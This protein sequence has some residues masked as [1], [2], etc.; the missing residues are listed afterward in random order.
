MHVIFG[1]SAIVMAIATVM[2]MARDHNREWK[3]WTL[4]DRKKDAWMIQSRRDAAAQQYAKLMNA[5]E[6]ELRDYDSQAV[7]TD[8]VL[9]FEELVRQENERLKSASPTVQ[10][11]APAAGGEDDSQEAESPDG[12][13]TKVAYE[14]TLV[15]AEGEVALAEDPEFAKLNAAVADLDSKTPAVVEAKEKL[16]TL[17]AELE[18]IVQAKQAGAAETPTPENAEAAAKSAAELDEQ[19]QTLKAEIKAAQ[20]ALWSAQDAAVVAR[21]NVLGEFNKFIRAAKFRETTLVSRKKSLNGQRTAKVSELGI[22]IGQGG[23]PGSVEKLQGEVNDLDRQVAELT[24]AIA[25][26][27]EYRMALEQV[28]SAANAEKVVAS[29]ELDTMNTELKRLDEQVAQNTS[30]AGEW[31]TRLPILNALYSGNVKVEQNWLPDLTINYNFSQVAR[32]DRCVT[33]HRGI[34][35]TAPGTASDP[36]YP[37]LPEEL[38][39]VTVQLA[40][41]EAQPAA[42][43]TLVDVYG[44]ELSDSGIVDDAA[45]TVHYVLPETPAAK[46]GI[47][48]GDVIQEIA[49]SR[50]FSPAEASER[51]LTLV[52]W[53]AKIPVALRRG[54]D[55]PY[56]SHPRLDLY[57][58]DTSPHPMKDVG[59]TICHDGQG[60]GTSFSWTSHTPN[61]AK[62]QNR[63][64]Q[65]YGWFDNHHW[66]FPMKPARFVESNCLKCHH[67]KGELEPS[68]KFP[69]PPAPQVVEGWTLVEEYGCFGCHEINGWDSPTASVG[70]DVRLEPNYA[71]VA[72]AILHSKALSDG[73]REMAQQLRVQPSNNELR[74]QLLGA[75]ASKPTPPGE[76]PTEAADQSPEEAQAQAELSRLATLLKDVEIPGEYRKV[77]PSLRYIKS[78]VDYDWLYSWVRKPA[79]FRPSTKMPQFFGLHEHLS[80]P[81]DASQ[82]AESQRFEPIEIRAITEYLLNASDDFEYLEPAQG[83]TEQASAERGEWQFESRGCLACHAHEEFPGIA[84]NQGPDLS[85]LGAKLNTEKGRRWLYSWVKQPNRY[86]ARTVMPELYIGPIVEKNA[87]NQPTGVVTDPAA[88]ITAFLLGVPTDWQPTDVPASDDWTVEDKSALADLAQLWLTSDAIPKGRARQYLEGEGFAE[89][90]RAKLKTNERVLI[91]LTDENRVERQ[92]EFVARNTI[93]KY[94]CFGCHD[95]PGFEDA[96]PIG[97]ALADWGRKETSKLAFENIH[98]FLETHSIN[99]ENPTHDAL[100]HADGSANAAET[101]AGDHAAAEGDGHDAAHAASH[102]HLDPADF[103]ADESYFVQSLNSHGRDGFIWQKLR[104]PRSYDYKTTRNKNFN[105]RLRM[106]KFPFN[107]QQRQAVI[108]F[109]LGL[110]KEPPATKFLFNPDA[111]QQAIVDGRQVLERFNCG[112]CHTLKMEQW[113]FGYGSDTFEDASEV[114]DYPFLDPGFTDQ[115]IAASLAKDTRGLLQANIAGQPVFDEETGQPTWVDED[116]QPITAEEVMEAE[117]EDG[118]AISVFYRFGLW[119]NELINGQPRLRGVDELLIPA[120][121]AKYGPANGN[122]Y[123]AWGGDLARYLFPKVIARAKEVNPQVNGREAWGWLPPPLMDEGKKVQTDWLHGFLMDPTMIRPAVVMRMPNFHMSSEEAEK[124]VNYFAAMSEAQFPFEYKPQQ[125]ANY[126]TN[127]NAKGGDPLAEAMNIVTNGNYCVKCHA[128]AD[129]APQGD[130]NTFGPN[131]ADV[132]SRL[133]PNFT[134]D[135]IAN[136]ARILPYTG[137]P[138]NIPYRPDDP[139]LGGVAQELYHGTSVQQLNGLVDLLM[140]FDAYARRNTSVSSLVERAAAAQPAG[141]ATPPAGGASAADEAGESTP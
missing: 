138:V 39:N 22:K 140:N 114:V 107:D 93:G 75:L 21:G 117:Q 128:V 41:P 34:A 19:E 97:T 12:E 4:K 53:N 86:H 79:D 6:D 102:G 44:M 100:P 120:D 113:V 30:N 141:G 28:V 129:F 61:D 23:E 29:K 110:V 119:A 112:G 80:D 13:V 3:D 137:M 47:E 38:R 55:H 78:K 72:G 50:V 134:R 62:E 66:I 11:A 10:E 127:L 87:Q 49:G 2:L 118:E 96:K 24:A 14:V 32:F 123:P 58:T 98:K 65:E 8:L 7:P 17:K 15:A 99:P 60:S 74:L 54:L 76:E 94:G 124:L 69:D 92:L 70:P 52:D 131:L 45:V 85:R 57:L 116:R 67:N 31:V 16:T 109:V 77:G 68:Q 106:P 71:E 88:D 82:L 5:Y 59:C 83:I 43:A 9:Q 26:A 36:M 125:R 139:H 33:C 111:R 126:L 64:A 35:K 115:Q 81:E 91:G 90:Q 84:S 121:R 63:W 48:S 27:K 136:P 56:T 40:T 101:P 130:P 51:L 132:Q 122:A 95:I 105:E 108:T 135:W 18:T 25:A 73:Q 133:R 103:S 89:S 46:A 42:G 104:Y 20:D 37:T 1:A